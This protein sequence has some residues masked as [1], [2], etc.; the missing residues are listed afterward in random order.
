MAEF[1]LYRF[2]AFQLGRIR[3]R[4]AQIRFSAS[5]LFARRAP[6]RGHTGSRAR[7]ARLPDHRDEV[8]LDPYTNAKERLQ[9]MVEL[10]QPTIASSDQ[11]PPTPSVAG[12]HHHQMNEL[13][14]PSPTSVTILAN[15]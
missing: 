2:V 6:G 13:A 12:R 10:Q 4:L 15:G 5:R 8:Y 9:L 7:A 14:S 3:G 1:S 11:P